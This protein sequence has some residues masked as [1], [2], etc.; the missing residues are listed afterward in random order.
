MSDKKRI[1]IIGSVAG[2]RERKSNYSYGAAKG[3]V[4]RYAQGLQHRFAG[5]E[6]RVILI[7]PGPTDTPMTRSLS[8]ING[9]LKLAPVE[10]VA[11]EIVAGINKGT[12]VIYTPQKWQ[13]IIMIGIITFGRIVEIRL[14]LMLIPM[15]T[16]ISYP[17]LRVQLINFK[18][19][20]TNKSTYFI[21]ER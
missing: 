19:M 18:Q 12:N 21:K 8:P 5:T 16:L 15:L 3:L 2:D 20:I 13:L 6:V 10:Q 1:V 4:T 7:K 17:V 14:Y 11:K 9:K